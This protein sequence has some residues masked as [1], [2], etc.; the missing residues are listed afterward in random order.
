MKVFLPYGNPET[1]RHFLDGI[2]RI[3]NRFPDTPLGAVSV[4]PD[5]EGPHN[6]AR[7]LAPVQG[8]SAGHITPLE[9]VTVEVN[10]QWIAETSF[11]GN[12]AAQDKAYRD[13]EAAAQEVRELYGVTDHVS[14][15]GLYSPRGAG[16]HEGT[17]AVV[18]TL[19]NKHWMSAGVV[20]G[21]PNALMDDVKA[22]VGRL[23]GIPPE[24]VR[25]GHIA[26][27][28]GPGIRRGPA[29][30]VA[31]AGADMAL[32][33]ERADPIHRQIIGRL[34]AAIKTERI[35]HATA[36]AMAPDTRLAITNHLQT[37]TAGLP[38]PSPSTIN[39]RT[40]AQSPTPTNAPQP[41][42][43]APLH[44]QEREKGLNKC[45]KKRL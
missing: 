22:S 19:P 44:R 11:A 1:T 13:F 26:A 30:M 35:R 25:D 23:L 10:P 7:T 24:T 40:P 42:G 43:I 12:M 39:P 41:P 15:P 4:A 3:L 36:H 21:F 37:A 34:A 38:P 6:F 29:E 20:A 17:H 45:R 2:Q 27:V 14:P 32:R 31:N 9:P 33:E 5:F 8:D 18:E 16:A 28:L